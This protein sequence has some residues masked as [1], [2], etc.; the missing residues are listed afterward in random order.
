[1]ENK[2]VK[3]GAM[4]AM[5]LLLLGAIAPL[6][7]A[8]PLS[9]ENRIAEQRYAESRQSFLQA[10]NIYKQARA[11]FFTAKQR[12]G[13]RDEASIT[14]AR[15]FLDKAITATVRYLENIKDFVAADWALSEAQKSAIAAGIDTDIQ[16]LEGKQAEIATADRAAL[17]AIGKEVRDYWAQVRV[18]LKKNVIAPILSARAD[19]LLMKADEASD[20]VL[21]AISEAEAR[22][23]D[24]TRAREILA[25]FD[26]KM[27]LAQSE[28][29]KAKAKF[30]E[31]NSLADA[32][33]FFRAAQEFMRQGN[34]YLR[35]AYAS[36]R[37][38]YA[39][40]RA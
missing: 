3:A 13:I 1:M 24:V 37:D 36:L 38:A 5:A 39:E 15:N 20:R 2:M 40:I 12:F 14:A 28:Y 4:F 25:D 19:W 31:I 7:S 30:A 21:N 18:D 10:E 11:D 6:I 9:E 8:V 26:S 22:G 29:D 33:E 35:Q 34:T 27:D 16:W 23:E 32:D 17:V